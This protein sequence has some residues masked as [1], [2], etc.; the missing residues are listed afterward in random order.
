[1]GH[2]QATRAAT[3]RVPTMIA[4]CGGT[5]TLHHQSTAKQGQRY[6]FLP[7]RITA[8]RSFGHRR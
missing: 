7:K 8:W 5:D 2:G 4:V 3:V 6:V 1:M